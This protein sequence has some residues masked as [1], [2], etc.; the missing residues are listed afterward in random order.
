MYGVEWTESTMTWY[1]DGQ[2]L[3]SWIRRPEC[4]QGLDM[5]LIINLA[6]GGWPG[7]PPGGQTWPDTYSCD[8][9]RVFQKA[10]PP[11]VDQSMHVDIIGFKNIQR[12]KGYITYGR[13]TIVNQDGVVVPNATVDI[14]WS[15]AVSDTDTAVTDDDG[16]AVFQ[17]PKKNGGGTFTLTVDDVSKSGVTYNAAQNEETTDSVVHPS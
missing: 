12:G 16:V 7:T 2:K 10:T 8:Y 9:V 4:A 13:V 17:S 14:T 1:F 3:Q 5:Y 11:S 15:G 6:C